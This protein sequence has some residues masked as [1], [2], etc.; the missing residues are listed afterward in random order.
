MVDNKRSGKNKGGFSEEEKEAMREHSRE[1]K[2]AGKTSGSGSKDGEKDVLAKISLMN[3]SDRR[4]A[5]RFH[6][7]VK[8]IAPELIPRTWYGMPAYSNSEGNVVCHFQPAAKFK[9][10]YATVGFSDKALLNQGTMWPVAF[11]VLELN[12]SEE[13]RI[14]D[15]LKKAVKGA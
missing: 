12:D 5:E 7:M 8:R 6:S 3:D 15:L 13:N 9:T 11:A 4:I 10:R 2:A 1:L 14:K